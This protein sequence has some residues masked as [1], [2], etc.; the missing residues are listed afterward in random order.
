MSSDAAKNAYPDLDW[1]WPRDG[2]PQGLLERV[3]E[4][5]DRGAREKAAE[6]WD[7]GLESG[8]RASAVARAGM[9]AAYERAVKNPYREAGL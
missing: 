9:E 2:F 6:A 5:Y 7:E 1:E 3:R 8:M 4:A